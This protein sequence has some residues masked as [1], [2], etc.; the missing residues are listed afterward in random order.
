MSARNNKSIKPAKTTNAFDLKEILKK[1]PMFATLTED[2][3]DQVVK[4][5]QKRKLKKNEVLFKEGDA[6]DFAYIIET[7]KIEIY[8]VYKR[9]VWK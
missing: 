4:I 7:G 6:G 5:C 9:G 8:G 3:L 2:A 1:M